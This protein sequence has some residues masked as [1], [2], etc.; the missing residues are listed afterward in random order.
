[1]KRTA[2]LFVALWAAMAGTPSMPHFRWESFT[3]ADGLPDNHVF[4]VCVDGDR[5]WAATEN[6]LGLYQN[7]KWRVFTPADNQ[8]SRRVVTPPAVRSGVRPDTG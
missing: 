4:S 3:T 8:T 2:L 1:M 6:G 5:V 7:G